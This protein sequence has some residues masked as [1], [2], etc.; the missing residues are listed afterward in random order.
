MRHYQVVKDD[1]V[2]GAWTS[3]ADV[4]D[5]VAGATVTWEG[6]RRSEGAYA[7]A[8]QPHVSGPHRCLAPGNTVVLSSSGYFR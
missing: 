6:C 1:L 8:I 3:V 4:C 2:F 5:Q 7:Y